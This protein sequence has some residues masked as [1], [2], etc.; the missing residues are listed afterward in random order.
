[1]YHLSVDPI[2]KYDLL[3][4]VAGVY[5]KA[6]II[7]P[8]DKLVIDRSLNSEKFIFATGFKPKPWPDLIKDMY[9]EYLLTN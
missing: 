3:N 6:N 9:Q 8:D 2:N 1:L 5:G 4:L 7:I